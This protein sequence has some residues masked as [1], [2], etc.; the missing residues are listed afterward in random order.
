MHYFDEEGYPYIVGR[1][2]RFGK[3][4]G[5]RFSFDDL[6]T[7]FQKVGINIVVLE[8]KE[9]LYLLANQEIDITLVDKALKNYA[10][11]RFVD[12]IFVIIEDIPRT[13]SGKVDYLSLSNQLASLEKS[14]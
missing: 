4:R 2:R 6:E 1:I 12:F 5:V 8:V 13:Q 10:G 11:L 9:K 3:V 7:M 14:I